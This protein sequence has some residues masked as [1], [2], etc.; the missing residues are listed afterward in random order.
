MTRRRLTVLCVVLA[1]LGTACGSSDEDIERARAALAPVE[2]EILELPG[3][4]RVEL[5]VAHVT[6]FDLHE[7]IDLQVV[8][9]G[10]TMEQLVDLGM[11]ATELVW[12]APLEELTAIHLQVRPEDPTLDDADGDNLRWLEQFGRDDLE[13]AFGPRAGDG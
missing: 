10:T 13:E 11:A 1:L 4:V 7:T 12:D 3:V 2:E 5:D 8:S 6:G 9:E